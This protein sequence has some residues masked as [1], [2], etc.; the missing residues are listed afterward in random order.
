MGK[1]EGIFKDEIVRLARREMKK[2]FVPMSKDVRLL[3]GTLS[4]VRKAVRE[5]ERAT[6]RQ[7]K[8][9]GVDKKPLTVAPEEVKGSRFSPRLIRSLR[10]RLGLTQR[11]LAKAAGVT[12]GAIYQ[13]ETGKFEPRA[14][15]KAV[16]VGLR[17]LGRREVREILEQKA[18]KAVEKVEAKEEKKAPPRK[19]RTGKV[20]RKRK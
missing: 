4:Q 17:K 15:K 13:W 2:V 18:P 10:E 1:F 19:R 14:D 6:A 5:L 3:K 12:V 11:E 16:L 9:A 8:E 20:S 7:I